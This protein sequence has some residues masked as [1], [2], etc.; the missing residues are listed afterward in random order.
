MKDNK[1]DITIA[2]WYVTQVLDAIDCVDQTNKNLDDIDKLNT[3]F[4]L[5]MDFD[6][7]ESLTKPVI[8]KEN[9]TIEEILYIGQ[10]EYIYYDLL[11][12]YKVILDY[13][14]LNNEFVDWPTQIA[15]YYIS[16]VLSD[17]FGMYDSKD[18][19]KGLQTTSDYFEDLFEQDIEDEYYELSLNDWSKVAEIFDAKMEELRC[20]VKE[21]RELDG[22]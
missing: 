21:Q 15:N 2:K 13:H 5:Y 10:I 12:P 18:Y 8:D 6:V 20:K 4:Y 14:R 11:D 22:I 19:P 9:K 1:E 16:I 3:C 17:V 7:V